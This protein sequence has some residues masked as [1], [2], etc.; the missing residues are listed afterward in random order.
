MPQY[1]SPEGRSYRE[2]KEFVVAEEA[3]GRYEESNLA[4]KL[5]RGEV[6]FEEVL[7]LF[8]DGKV[9]RPPKETG[10]SADNWDQIEANAYGDPFANLK[11]KSSGPT[12]TLEQYK[13]IK[14]AR[15]GYVDDG[16]PRNTPR[17][18]YVDGPPPS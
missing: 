11:L 6:T 18:T 3:E 9:F 4:S 12:L 7:Q 10:R 1:E 17:T 13:E 8:R 14:L 16:D 2:W 15:S 5:R